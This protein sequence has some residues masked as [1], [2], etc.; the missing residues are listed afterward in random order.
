MASNYTTNYNLCQWQPTDQVQRTDFNA[1]NAKLDAALAALDSGK[2]DQSALTSLSN[3]VA[4]KASQSALNAA[5]ATIPHFT[6]GTYSGNGALERTI[7]LGITPSMVLLF[8]K[9]GWTYHDDGIYG[10]L[11]FTGHPV[12]GPTIPFLEIV[13]NG[14]RIFYK[15]TMEGYICTNRENYDYQYVAISW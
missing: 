13:E 4:Q 8:T 1:D 6:F 7:E 3:T 5:A 12:S 9:K 15:S 10:G 11:A 14:F 2:A